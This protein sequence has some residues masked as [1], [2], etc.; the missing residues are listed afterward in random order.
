MG[1]KFEQVNNWG[2]INRKVFFTSLNQYK[3]EK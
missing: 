2:F 3:V 1:F